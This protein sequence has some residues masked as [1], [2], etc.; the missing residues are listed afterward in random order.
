MAEEMNV[1]ILTADELVFP[2]VDV[3]VGVVRAGAAGA[4]QT[5]AMRWTDV[6]SGFILRRMCQLIS[7]SV[8]T[9]KAFK[10]VHLN[11]VAKALQEFSGN[12]V[13]STQVYNHLRKWR[14]RWIRIS[15]LRELSGALWDEDNSMIVLKEEN[16]NGH[17]KAHPKD[18]EYLNKP[19]HHY[20]QMMIIF[21]NGQAIGK[22][23]MGSNEALSSPSDF[24][25]SSL[26]N[27][28]P[29]ELKSGKTE[30]ADGTKSKEA[31]GSKRKRCMLSEEDVLVFT[32]MTDAVNNVVDAISSTKVEDSHPEL[33]GALMFMPGFS[34][35]ALMVAYGHLLD[36][37]V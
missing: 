33:Y 14:Q 20:Q 15:K 18:A 4:Q 7:T 10:E 16:Y 26:K 32:S 24:V 2:S 31:V 11:Q 5:S 1:E 28:S 22:Y 35:E 25:E 36:N 12:D 3:P 6:M 17:I 29:E 27:E 37:K 19:I 34:D 21:G 9:D 23:A 13:T 8:R 30:A